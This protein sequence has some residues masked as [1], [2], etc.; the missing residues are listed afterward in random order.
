[1]GI[2]VKVLFVL[3]LL[4]MIV[5]ASF[6]FKEIKDVIPAKTLIWIKVISVILCGTFGMLLFIL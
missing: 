1:M 4:L 6:A 5:I 3:L 2:V